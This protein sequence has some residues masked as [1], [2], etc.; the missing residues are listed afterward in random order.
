MLGLPN[1]VPD[2][3]LALTASSARHWCHKLDQTDLLLPESLSDKFME[4]RIIGRVM[5]SNV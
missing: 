5:V 3:R 4:S 1:L 2:S